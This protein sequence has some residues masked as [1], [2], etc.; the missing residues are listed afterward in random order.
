VAVQWNEV[1]DITFIADPIKQPIC[2]YN[3][4]APMLMTC[5]KYQKSYLKIVCTFPILLSK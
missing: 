3:K 5:T 4:S 2:P 1:C